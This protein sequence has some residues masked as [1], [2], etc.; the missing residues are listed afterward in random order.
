[1]PKSKNAKLK[2]QKSKS[3]FNTVA[4]VEGFTQTNAV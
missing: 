2:M 3:R 4:V 1:M